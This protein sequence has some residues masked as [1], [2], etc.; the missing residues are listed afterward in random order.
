MCLTCIHSLSMYAFKVMQV[1]NRHLHT[2]FSA[3]ESR[4]GS[5]EVIKEK[6]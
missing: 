1:N 4:G 5:L 6:Q 2:S 3:K